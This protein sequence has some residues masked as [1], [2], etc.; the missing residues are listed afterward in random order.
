MAHE[1]AVPESVL[2]FLQEHEPFR[3]LSQKELEELIRHMEVVYFPRGARILKRGE[4]ENPYVY[5]VRKGAV[6]LLEEDRPIFL[7]EEGDLFGF[8]SALTQ[9]PPQFDVLATEDVLAYRVHENHLRPYLRNPRFARYFTQSF[10]DR[11]RMAIR[12]ERS[13]EVL[14]YVQPVGALI[15]REPVFVEPGDTVQKAARIMT[16][17]RI[18]SVLIRQD[19]L[20]IVTDRDLRSRVLAAGRGPETRVDAIMTSPV[21]TL[22]METPMFEAMLFMLQHNIHH[23]PLTRDGSVIGVITDTDILRQQAR[24]PLHLLRH[25]KRMVRN[26][27][28]RQYRVLV[29]GLV[30]E[31]FREGVDALS[32]GRIVSIL[33]DTLVRTLLTHQEEILGP[34]PVPYAWMVM[35]SEGR[36]EQTLLTDQD[37]ALVYAEPPGGDNAYFQQL[38]QRTVEG[39]LTAGFPPCPGGYMATQ[40]SQPLETWIQRYR[41]WIEEPDTE[42]LLKAA[43]FFD[44]RFVHGELSPEPL[45]TVIRSAGNNQVFLAHMAAAALRWRPPLGLFHRL[46]QEKGHIDIKKGGI[47]PIVALARVLALEAG[48]SERNTATRLKVAKEARRISEQAFENLVEAYRFLLAIRLEHQL[49][50]LKEGKEPDNLIAPQELSTLQ[51]RYL[52]EAFVIIL[53][54]QRSLEERYQLGRF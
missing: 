36:M 13:E 41:S 50:R 4:G 27:E 2:S 32:I 54:V 49:R 39:L 1:I 30:Q 19:P 29:H 35:G 23:L 34:P 21:R 45:E 12:T 24:S 20:G 44:F 10:A 51:R 40:W 47:Q 48:S 31:L 7:L 6:Q 46:R 16:N 15:H 14:R 8:P 42:A 33:N 3:Q 28:L 5:I 18:S 25:I 11:L 38:A 22:P 9:S 26:T 17:E 43:I 53:E 37:N 52:K